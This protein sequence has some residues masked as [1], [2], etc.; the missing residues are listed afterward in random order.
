[1]QQ[2]LDSSNKGA[3]ER[4]YHH[5]NLKKALVDAFIGLLET[6]NADKISMRKLASDIGVAP[7]AV[8]NHFK[9][10]DELAIAVKAQCL[11]HFADY[12]ELHS[13][14]ASEPKEQIKELGKA[15]FNYSLEHAQF[16]KLI[17]G[18]A[19][20]E[21][22]VTEDLIAAGKRAE[23]SIRAAV[24]S[25]LK[26][27]DIPVTQYNEGMGAFACWSIAHG[28][29]SL[30]EQKVNHLACAE[31]RWPQDFMLSTPEQVHQSFNVM[32]EVLVAGILST[33][34]KHD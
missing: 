32:T 6:E 10:K 7:T 31:G 3:N 15:Y 29:S 11:N 13:V 27:H 12:L 25:L 21:Q 23:D 33:S 17:M 9:S 24:L 20:P 16:F 8:Y 30:A 28:I 26:Q 14:H 18:T 22:L 5:G 34:K 4:N 19:V 2:P 1:M